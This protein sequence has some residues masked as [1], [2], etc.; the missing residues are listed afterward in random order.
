M[1]RLWGSG[2]NSQHYT[3]HHEAPSQ[4]EPTLKFIA[5]HELSCSQMN[6]V[7]AKSQEGAGHQSCEGNSD[8]QV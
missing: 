7:G 8:F 2:W 3:R 6:D 4:V 5:V 1:F